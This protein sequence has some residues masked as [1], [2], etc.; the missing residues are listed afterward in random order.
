M[1]KGKR[2]RAEYGGMYNFATGE[3]TK[4]DP[5]WSGI[6]PPKDLIPRPNRA[7]RRKLIKGAK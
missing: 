4:I 6:K 7:T 2:L 5:E 3:Q 1:S